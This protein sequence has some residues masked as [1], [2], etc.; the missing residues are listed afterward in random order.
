MRSSVRS[1]ARRRGRQLRQ[2]HAELVAAEPGDV[3]LGADDRLEASRQLAQEQVAGV[4]AERVVDLLEPVEVDQQHG[5]LR[6]VARTAFDR[7]LT[8]SR[9]WPRLGSPVRPSCDA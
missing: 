9:K 4:V 3:S 8:R 1:S 5:E 7:L 6:A 2:Q